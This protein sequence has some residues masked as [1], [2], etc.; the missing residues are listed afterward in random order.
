MNF[1]RNNI[2]SLVGLFLT[3]GGLLIHVG[4]TKAEIASTQKE[5]VEF[6]SETKEKIRDIEILNRTTSEKVNEKLDDLNKNMAVVISWI[7]EQKRREGNTK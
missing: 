6:K 5:L 3:I 4:F 1:F 7:D 2:V